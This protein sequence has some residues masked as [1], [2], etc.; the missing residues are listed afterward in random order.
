V[1]ERPIDERVRR[2]L[3]D[4]ISRDHARANDFIGRLVT[5]RIAIAGLAG[6]LWTALLGVGFAFDRPEALLA[7]SILVAALGV[8]DL[9]YSAH[10]RILRTQVRRLERALNANYKYTFRSAGKRHSAAALERALA[11][12]EIGQ[13]SPLR[14]HRLHD[15]RSAGDL[16]TAFFVALALAA[17]ALAIFSALFRF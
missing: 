2:E 7:G 13:V 8:L 15:L 1:S 14:P 6:S 9:S 11:Q 17:I 5:L 4:L 12:V 16:R 3:I 10:Y